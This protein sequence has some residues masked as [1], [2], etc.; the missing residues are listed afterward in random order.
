MRKIVLWLLIVAVCIIPKPRPVELVQNSNDFQLTEHGI[1]IESPPPEI[2]SFPLVEGTQGNI[3]H[4][5][6]GDD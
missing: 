2:R 3:L 6:N 5:P 4:W 1:I